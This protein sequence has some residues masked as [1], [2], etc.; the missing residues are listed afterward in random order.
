MEKILKI[1]ILFLSIKSFSQT[2]YLLLNAREFGVDLSNEKDLYFHDICINLNKIIDKDVTLDYRRKYLFHN[3]YSYQSIINFERPLRNNSNDC[4]FINNSI[5]SFFSNISLVFILISLIQILLIIMTFI[6][7]VSDSFDNTPYEK[8][9]LINQKNRKNSRNINVE[10]NNNKINNGM[11]PYTEFTAEEKKEDNNKY[12]DSTNVAMIETNLTDSKIPFNEE[13]ADK[14]KNETQN[15]NSLDEESEKKPDSKIELTSLK[16][17]KLDSKNQNNLDEIE[18]PKEKST[19]NYTFGFNLGTKINMNNDTANVVNE[20]IKEEKENSLEKKEDK[21]KRIRQIYDE[22]NPN[23]KKIIIK[24]GNNKIISNNNTNNEMEVFSAPKQEK[25]IYVREEY[26]YF[27]Y[28][29]ARMEDKRSV[30][31]IY[32]DLLEQC[33]IVFK[34]YKNYFNIYEDR[35]IQILYYLTKIYLYSL[36]NCLLIKSS[37]I[38]DIYDNKNNFFYDFIRSLKATIIT[39]FICLFL[40]KLTNIKRLLIKRRYKLINIKISNIVLKNEMTELTKTISQ[41]F[42]YNKFLIFDLFIGII[43]SYSYYVSFCFMKVYPNTQFLLLKCIIIS[44]F[45]SQLIPFV[46]CLIPAFIR[47]K[48]INLKKVKLY[49]ITKIVEFFFVA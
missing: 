26:F 39:Y 19:D 43:V 30:F 33:Q 23:K 1:I 48:A 41:N 2:E 6:N 27:K 7:K 4:F 34:F 22:I 9:K 12:T 13:E 49:D 8:L 3:K 42:L 16:I 31:Q 11:N 32:V 45:I 36:F 37:V 21:I 40:Y 44:V 18:M 47:K 17:K 35:K 24:N 38:N 46:A 28:L 25:K 20:P 10:K 15:Q 29:L 5:D 14:N